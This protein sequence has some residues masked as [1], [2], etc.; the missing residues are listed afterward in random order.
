MNK[1]KTTLIGFLTVIGLLVST[2]GLVLAEDNPGQFSVAPEVPANQKSGVTGYYDLIVTKGQEETMQLK[3]TNSSDK[4]TTYEAYVNP[5]MTSDGGA[6]DYAQR[7][8]KID[9]T[10]PFD[11]RDAVTL[12]KHEYEVDAGQT[13]SIPIHVKIPNLD[14]KGRVLGGIN[15]QKKGD[16][17]NTGS[18]NGSSIKTKISYS[19]GIVLQESEEKITP[20]LSYLKT[21]PNKVNGY[22]TIQMK[23]RN[24]TPTIIPD[25]IF[26][27]TLYK[28][29]TKFIENTSN[30][31]TVAPNTVFNV[32]LGLNGKRVEAGKYKVDITAK[33]GPFYKWHFTDEFEITAEKAAEVNKNAIFE[34]KEGMNI[35]MIIAIIVGIIFLIVLIILLIVILKRKK[36]D[37]DDKT[38]DK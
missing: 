29:G 26:T 15:V 18:Q 28:N 24:P 7:D 20:D 34:E 19:V 2:N 38:S 22:T 12:D 11:I 33:S 9:K 30:K 32:N 37:D 35:W 3:L 13:I 31:Y 17:S 1:L 21:T 14:W 8:A 23:F 6:I 36:K 5:A 25:L 4:K 10:V 27:T 16:G